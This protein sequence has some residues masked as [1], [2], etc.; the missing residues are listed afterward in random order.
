MSGAYP[1]DE[2]PP[3]VIADGFYAKGGHA[4]NLFRILEQLK[5]N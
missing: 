4:K 1:G 5:L 3:E 2:L